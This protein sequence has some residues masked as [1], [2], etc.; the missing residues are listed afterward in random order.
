MYVYG[1]LSPNYLILLVI[2]IVF[3]QVAKFSST[4]INCSNAVDI[5]R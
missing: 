2:H 3:V 1:D 5:Y 4:W